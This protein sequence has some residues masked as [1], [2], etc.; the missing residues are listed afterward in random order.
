MICGKKVNIVLK[1]HDSQVRQI[2]LA[3]TAREVIIL[4]Q[5]TLILVLFFTALIASVI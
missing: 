2:V 1:P 3:I 4:V 5:G